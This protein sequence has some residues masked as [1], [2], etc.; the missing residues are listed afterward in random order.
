MISAAASHGPF[1]GDIIF[2]YETVAREAEIERKPLHQHVQHLV[3]HGLLHLLGHDH[4]GDAEA[5]RMERLEVEVL[6]RLGI[7][8]PYAETG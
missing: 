5:M 7:P 4:E 8:D 6:A 3:V 2:A 1:L